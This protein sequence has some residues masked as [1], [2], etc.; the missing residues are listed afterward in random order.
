MRRITRA[1]VHTSASPQGRGDDAA[2]IHQ[3]HTDRHPPFDG[4]GYHVVILEDGT[5]Q[6]GRP[7]CWPGA[8]VRGANYNSVGVCLIGEGPDATPAQMAR[9][10][11]V[12]QDW[13]RRFP[14]LEVMG[15]SDLDDK[16][17]DCPGWDVK[18]WWGSL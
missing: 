10:T 16:K 14:N 1:V 9:L 2:T 3:W 17:P 8:H 7:L 6:A 12:L 15:H 13:A 4:I 11:L 18:K 5:E